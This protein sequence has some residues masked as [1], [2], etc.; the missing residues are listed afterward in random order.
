MLPIS[1]TLRLAQLALVLFFLISGPLARAQQWQWATTGGG[2]TD[3]SFRQMAADGAGNTYVTG[4][5]YPGDSRFGTTPLPGD[6]VGNFTYIAKLSPAGNWLWAVGIPAVAEGVGVDSTGN[7]YVLAI[8]A[9]SIQLGSLHLIGSGNRNLF[10]GKLSPSGVWLRA[11]PILATPYAPAALSM[12]VDA[13]GNVLLSGTTDTQTTATFGPFSVPAGFALFVAKLDPTG[14][15]EWVAHS[16]GEAVASS[17]TF[18]HTGAAVVGG[19]FRQT[20]RFGSTTLATGNPIYQDLFVAK[21][22]PAGQWQWA[23]RGGDSFIDGVGR[24]IVDAAND[25]M[26]TGFCDGRWTVGNTTVTY[27][28]VAKISRDGQWQWGTNVGII[29]SSPNLWNLS[30]ITLDGPSNLLVTGSFQGAPTVGNTTLTSAGGTDILVG[31]I[32]GQT[33]AWRW[34]TSFGSAD[35]EPA[36]YFIFPDDSHATALLAGRFQTP[37]ALGS[38]PLVSAGNYD[39]FVAKLTL[40]NPTGL[41]NPTSRSSLTL[42]PNPTRRAVQVAGVSSGGTLEV[43]DALGRVVRRQRAE[44]IT[45][46][47]LSGLPAGTYA[48]RCG[49]Q[50]QRLIVE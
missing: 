39:L 20:T 49:A 50:T 19:F 41:A 35:N 17:V 33:G 28:F 24:L 14:T 30:A 3:E 45:Q 1:P 21:I 31:S 22:T 4:Q 11:T 43:H 10:I 27:S 5:Y 15:W 38:Y 36:P 23:V 16:V 2:A 44:A 9:D 32:D 40:P 18:D 29:A 8:Y 42:W 37:F 47:D 13:G 46:L 7:V 26:M 25:I 12:A 6:S 34:A 48:V